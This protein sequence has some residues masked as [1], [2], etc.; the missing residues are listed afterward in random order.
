MD[1]GLPLGEPLL[2]LKPASSLISGLYNNEFL[3]EQSESQHAAGS[4]I[5]PDFSSEILYDERIN[6]FYV[7]FAHELNQVE[8]FIGA[9]CG[10]YPNPDRGSRSVQEG[11]ENDYNDLF[12]FCSDNL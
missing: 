1:Y 12:P 10:A 8:L 7:N 4:I 11:F 2:N 9:S 3:V 6:A 5:N